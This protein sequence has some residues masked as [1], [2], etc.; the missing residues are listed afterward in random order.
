MAELLPD[1]AETPPE[2]HSKVRLVSMAQIDRRTKAAQIALETKDAIIADLGGV[3]RLSTLERL[4]AENAA[5]SA[6]ILRDAHVRW[7]RGEPVP[8]SEIAT[9]ENTFNRTA[10]ALGLNRRAKDVTKSI[11]GYIEEKTR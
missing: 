8:V 10:A 2:R 9:L 6:A 3:E 5:V 4:M 7:L 1:E 11:D